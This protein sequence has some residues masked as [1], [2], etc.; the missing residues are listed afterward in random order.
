MKIKLRYIAIIILCFL[1][2]NG[3]RSYEFAQSVHTYFLCSLP[4]GTPRGFKPDPSD[5]IKDVE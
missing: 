2:F 3:G 1:S 5:C 4:E